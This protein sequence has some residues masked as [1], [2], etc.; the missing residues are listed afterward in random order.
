MEKI[1]SILLMSVPLVAF[2]HA[3]LEQKSV[4]T[5]SY[6]KG[7]IGVGHGCQG[8]TTTSITIEI[9]EGVQRAKPMPKPGWSVE[10]MKA[11]LDTPYTAYGKEYKEDVHQIIWSGGEL[12]DQ[13]FEEFSFRAKIS[14]S[15]QT[16][17]F[18]TRQKCV[19][20]EIYWHEIPAADKNPH[21]YKTPAPTLNVIEKSDGQHH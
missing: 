1:L 11:K 15:P 6:Y 13:H 21:D 2:S 20:G 5:G 8:S 19:S 18:P 16:L 4:E 7:V 14:A 10:V 3:T 9:P 17:Y 12:L